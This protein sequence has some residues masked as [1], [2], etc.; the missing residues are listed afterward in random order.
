[1]KDPYAELRAMKERRHA[2]CEVLNHKLVDFGY[3]KGT[4]Y[5]EQYP[6]IGIKVFHGGPQQAMNEYVYQTIYGFA[7]CNIAQD[8]TLKEGVYAWACI[9]AALSSIELHKMVDRTKC[10]GILEGYVQRREGYKISFNPKSTKL[11]AIFAPWDEEIH[12]PF[13]LGAEDT[14]AF[15]LPPPS[16]GRAHTVDKATVCD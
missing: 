13:E 11:I 10:L 1:M 4:Q 8:Q 16:V 9:A 5:P 12:L 7:R 14:L 3:R 2:Y 6:V 15:R